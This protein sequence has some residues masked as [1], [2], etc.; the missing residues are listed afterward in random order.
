MPG[1]SAALAFSA[2]IV[3]STRGCGD[4]FLDPVTGIGSGVCAPFASCAGQEDVVG[5]ALSGL[6]CECAKP[7]LPD[8]ARDYRTAPYEDGGC[9]QP[10]SMR[11]LYIVARE[12][13][14]VL[15]KP[16]DM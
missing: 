6:T 14:A 13:N 11:D 3:N 10:R 16:G 4:T 5:T 15:A 9:I 8:P 12:V 7:N 1:C 2:G